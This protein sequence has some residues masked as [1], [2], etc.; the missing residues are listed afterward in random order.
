MKFSVIIPI[1]NAE[2]TIKRCINSFISQ[3]YSDFEIILV[4][5]GSSD[6]SEEIILSFKSDKIKYIKKENGGV[7]S[8]RNCGISVSTGDIICF[9]DADDYVS[10]NY[11]QE[12]HNAFR[13]YDCD[14]VFFGYNRIESTKTFSCLP[15]LIYDNYY[16]NLISL[17]KSDTF[18]YPW[19]KAVK[20]S[21]IADIRFDESISL[22]ED[23]IFSLNVFSNYCKIISISKP[24]YNY[25]INSDSLSFKVHQDYC[26][27]CD[28]VYKTWKSVLAGIPSTILEEKANHFA[29]ICQY[30]GIEKEIKVIPFYRQL[31]S[32]DFFHD[33]TSTLQSKGILLAIINAYWIRIKNKLKN[34]INR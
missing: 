15:H 3:A 17:T 19:V 8:A 21:M 4:N 11:F 7:S 9:A 31:F 13:Y 24:L 25:V 10:T 1:Y 23:E 12:L 28:T 33:S 18:G 2:S 32:C 16:Q 34:I 26:S 6:S 20:R 30:Y 5:D 22:Y 14:A 27:I 29:M